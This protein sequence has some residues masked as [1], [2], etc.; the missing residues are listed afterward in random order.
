MMTWKIYALASAFF[1]GL[2]ALFAK[3]GV[4]DIPSNFATLFRTIVILMFLFIW[5][6]FRQEWQNPFHLDRK[7]V[8]FLVLSGM[9]TGLSWLCYFRALQ[10]GPASLV[11]P[12]DKLS[13]LFAVILSVVI[14]REQL[15]LIQWGGA[16]FMTVGALMMALK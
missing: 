16:M 7:T 5:V 4:R 11:A 2:T 14:L 8:F 12:L 13:L 15:S 6:M 9:A 3:I 1:A 10:L